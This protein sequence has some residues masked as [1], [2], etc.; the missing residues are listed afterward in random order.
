MVG[1]RRDQFLLRGATAWR[2]T[3]RAITSKLRVILAIGKKR[4]VLAGTIDWPGL[5]RSR[6]SISRHTY[7]TEPEN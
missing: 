3:R 2:R 1:R 4:R 7:G 5:G 6:D